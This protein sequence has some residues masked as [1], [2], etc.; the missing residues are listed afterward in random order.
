MYD[1][2][3]DK[4]LENGNDI[5]RMN[6]NGPKFDITDCGLTCNLNDK[7]LMQQIRE[8]NPEILLNFNHS[9]PVNAYELIDKSCKICVLDADNPEFFW[10]A[11]RLKDHY[12][13][14]M[15]LGF[16]AYSKHMFEEFIG[17]KLEEGSNYLF[18]P[19]ATSIKNENLVQDKNISFIG[20]NFYP[21]RMPKSSSFYSD[22]AI[23]LYKKF[24]NDY[25][26]SYDQMKELGREWNLHPSIFSL[27]KKFYIGQGRLKYMQ[28]LSD[29]GFVYYGDEWEKI[30]SYDFELAGCF[31][32][33]LI[34][35]LEDNQ[36]VYNT[37]KIAVNIS[38]PQAKSSFS[39]RVMDIMASNACLLMEY[40][41]DW[42]DLFGPYLSRET[43]D[44]VIYSDRYDMRQKAIR[45]L[46]D[47]ALR[48]RCVADL[49]KA[50]R[51][52]GRWEHRFPMLEKFLHI[53]LLGLKNDKPLYIYIRK[54]DGNWGYNDIKKNGVKKIFVKCIIP[55]I[56]KR[57]KIF[58]YALC[59]A[60][61]QIPVINLFFKQIGNKFLRKLFN[62]I[63]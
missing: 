51:E 28:V 40:K 30:A 46:N 2:I 12:T 22:K 41:P 60:L 61:I 45:L 34:S 18:F 32:S 50:I 63:D 36:L 54:K 11:Q 15:Y 42:I 26:F 13:E 53:P 33:T 20:T 35:T 9:F 44:S 5:F 19:S 8:F 59:V 7:V 47:D 58:F 4:L 14:Y 62:R 25:L 23:D 39:W 1:S 10:H 3:S 27:I 56:K 52:N 29:L 48:K 31:N 38:H 16:Q 43:I 57:C 6:T 49:N 37:S 17:T 55:N 24:E 21:K